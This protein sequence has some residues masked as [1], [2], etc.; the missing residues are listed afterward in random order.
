MERLIE[1]LATQPEKLAPMTVLDQL[2]RM[3]MPLPL[4]L[5][6]WKV[7]NTYWELLQKVA[8]E[9]YARATGGD[10]SARA[11]VNQFFDL[12]RTLGF[13]LKDQEL[14]QEAVRAAA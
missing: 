9:V 2:A 3:V 1:Q 4:G 8:S 7:Q 10:E 5:N 14:P 12:G 6:L 11:W 13:A